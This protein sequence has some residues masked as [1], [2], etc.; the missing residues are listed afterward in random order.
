[1]CG[2]CRKPLTTMRGRFCSRKCRQSAFR[3]RKRRT[4]ETKHGRP[5]RVAYADP[6]YPGQARKRYGT[7]EVDH[8]ALLKKLATFDGWA[9][10]TSARALR[11]VLP[12]CPPDVRVAS[13]VKL[14]HGNPRTRGIHNVWEAVIVKPARNLQPG[15][16]DSLVAAAA[17]GGEEA[18]Q[19]VGRK[20]IAFTAWLFGLLGTVAGDTFEDLFPGTGA[21]SRAWVELTRPIPKRQ[22][23]RRRP[24]SHK[25]HAPAELADVA[26]LA[27]VAGLG[28]KHTP[29]ELP[30]APADPGPSP[31]PDGA[32]EIN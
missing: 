31:P 26:D 21:V 1:M 28:Q 11:A 14:Q 15:V 23:R 24:M 9:L 3:V 2:W 30:E 7:K 20:P 10:S 8:R 5:M 4:I 27:L 6:P 13:W 18:D 22:R 32:D 19:L 25:A 17:R 12:L 16:P 29:G